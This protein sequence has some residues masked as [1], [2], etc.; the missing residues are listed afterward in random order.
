MLYQ[1]GFTEQD[2]SSM[3]NKYSYYFHPGDIVAGTVFNKEDNGFLVDI[4]ADIAGYL[5]IEEVSLKSKKHM[6][7]SNLNHLQNTTRE[8][9]ILAYNENSQQLILSI[10]RLEYIRAWKRIKQLIKEDIIFSLSIHTINKGGII[11]YIEGLQGFIP[12]SHLVIAEPHILNHQIKCKML[13]ADEKTNQ[14]IFS[15]KSA[16]LYLATNKIKIGDIV[17]GVIT[18]IKTYGLFIQIHDIPALLHI[19]EIGSQYID[20]LHHVFKMGNIIKVKILHIDTKQGRL[21]VSKR[22]ID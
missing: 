8:F 17:Y 5:P 4:G 10:K 21:S 1:K 15:N 7:T 2:F 14:I 11:T 16:V 19:S 6:N 22:N 18:N 13:I 9:F 12:N 20:N 3:L